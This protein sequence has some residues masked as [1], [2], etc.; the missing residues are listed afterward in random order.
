MSESIRVPAQAAALLEGM[1]KARSLMFVVSF[2]GCTSSQPQGP[3]VAFDLTSKLDK[4]TYWDLP[5]PSDLRLTSDGKPD[6]AS[7]PNKRHLPVVEDLLSAAS[8]RAGFPVMPIAWF[9]FTDKAPLHTLDQIDGTV[10]LIDVDPQ[11]SER[12]MRYPAVAQTLVDDDYTGHGLVAVAPRPGIVLRGHTRYALALRR[13]FAPDAE[14]PATFAE[15]VAGGTPAGDRGAAAATLYAPLWPTLDTIGIAHDDVLVATVFT[16]GDEVAVLAKRSDA[17]HT[18]QHA[19]ISDVHLGRSAFPGVC[20]IV[21]SV[22]VP[23]FQVGAP[24]F[25]TAGRFALDGSGIPM[26]QGSMTVPL[27]ITLPKTAMPANGWPLWQFFHGS[28]GLSSDIVEDGPSPTS[29]DIPVVGEGPGYVVARRGIAAASSALPLNPERLPG[30]SNYA[31]LNFNNLSAFPYTF[32][33]GVFEQRML[34]DALLALQIPQATVA[35]C[36]GTSLPANATSHHFDPSKLVAG[37]HSMGGMYT[38]MIGAVEPRFG[39]L[40][41]FGAGGFWNM[42][43]LDTAIV[44]GARDLL[45]GV[46]GVDGAELSFAHP[47][48]SL[49]ELGWEIADPINSMARMAHPMSGSPRHIYQPIGMDDKFFP[50]PI[51]DAAALA[52][53]NQEAGEIVWP[54][55]QE[56]LRAEHMDGIIAYPVKGNRTT[57]AVVVQY[58][59]DGILDAHYIHRQLPA[60]K[61]QYG[62][63]LATY[64]RDGIP[65]V[66]AP[67]ALDAA[68]P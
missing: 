35:A 29:A 20:E 58:H 42:M 67:A 5:F 51:F 18:T 53:G 34:L 55:T 41:P 15:L 31:Y 54:G 32:Q 40:T 66:P 6:L 27:T 10:L 45:A 44:P 24:P 47:A 59:D 13:A 62:C 22:T 7:F 2:L 9:R 61:Y 57:T 33:Q 26:V 68:C 56:A 3:T 60:V 30:A 17:V 28:G 39:A 4:T 14:I 37:G 16:T 46:L 38:N 49:V 52:Y 36:T 50:N 8:E 48:L 12:G 64:L 25:D 1:A 63:F 19:T 11:S 65:T 43:I 23:Q 21:A